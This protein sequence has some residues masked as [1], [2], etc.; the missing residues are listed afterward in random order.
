MLSDVLVIPLI[1]WIATQLVKAAVVT[2]RT[3]HFEW[4]HLFLSGG[5]PSSHTATVTAVALMVGIRNGF[6]S[7]LFAVTVV[8]AGIVAYDALGVRRSTGEQ[9]RMINRILAKVFPGKKGE[10]PPDLR[11]VLGHYPNEVLAGI[12]FGAVLTYILQFYF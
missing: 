8:F 1:V 7:S 9:A 10:V 6:D 5:M 3:K 11:V 2:N 12:L 4:R